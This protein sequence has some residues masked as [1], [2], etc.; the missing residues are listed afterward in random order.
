MKKRIF[1]ILIIVPIIIVC[2][3]AN[4]KSGELNSTT[5][6]MNDPRQIPSM[7]PIKVQ[8]TQE[9]EQLKESMERIT[10]QPTVVPDSKETS[11][12]EIEAP[13]ATPV[14]TATPAPTTV[15]EA[16]PTATPAPIATEA[17]K[18]SHITVTFANDNE[19]GPDNEVTVT[20]TEVKDIS[21]GDE[22]IEFVDLD[23]YAAEVLRLTN[24]ERANRGLA[25]LSG[26][27]SLLQSAA[28][29]RVAE[30]LVS[31]SHTRPDG[32]SFFTVFE[33]NGIDYMHAGENISSGRTTPQAQVDGWMN[34][35]GHRNNILNSN[36]THIGVGVK[37]D[38][39]GVFYWVQLFIG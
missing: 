37:R 35:E 7:Q 25:A 1:C 18:V 22:E 4:K 20:E 21:E 6:Q 27:N 19:V 14:P 2:L 36:S 13:T 29:T 8:E 16:T 30:L 26:N 17:H 38:S 23:A 3:E 33:D 11:T 24:I 39:N 10:V 9:I 12:E 15:P 31:A 5:V 32:R 28:K 34:S